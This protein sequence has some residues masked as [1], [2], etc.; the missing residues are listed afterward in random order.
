M[1][2]ILITDIH[3]RILEQEPSQIDHRSSAIAKRFL[4]S[5]GVIECVS[6]SELIIEKLSSGWLETIFKIK[7]SRKRNWDISKVV[8]RYYSKSS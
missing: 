4:V 7:I 5:G 1:Y 8:S 2:Y 3:F 6:D